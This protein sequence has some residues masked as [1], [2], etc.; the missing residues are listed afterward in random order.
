MP[1]DCSAHRKVVSSSLTGAV[2][3]L[4]NYG[5]VAMS[6]V[7]IKII[8]PHAYVLVSYN[9]RFKA[10]SLLVRFIHF[11]WEVRTKYI[12]R[13]KTSIIVT[14]KI[15][16]VLVRV[17]QAKRSILAFL[18]QVN[19]S[20]LAVNQRKNQRERKE[21]KTNTLIDTQKVELNPSGFPGGRINA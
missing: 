16:I 1:A 9:N 12:H 11:F 8:T 2:F 10:I 15:L 3:L 4:F 13:N 7:A 17:L 21:N 14:K 6:R 19:S 18:L 5:Q 20:Y